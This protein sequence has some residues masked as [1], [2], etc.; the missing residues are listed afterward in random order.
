MSIIGMKSTGQKILKSLS[1]K[2][3]FHENELKKE[4]KKDEEENEIKEILNPFKEFKPKEI[5]E[6]LTLITFKY[7][8]KLKPRYKKKKI[9]FNQLKKI[10]Q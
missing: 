1:S 10:F 8:K 2:I 3:T 7:F 4:E 5:S 9:L 6:Q